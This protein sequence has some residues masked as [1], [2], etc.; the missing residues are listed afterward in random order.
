M[1]YDPCENG[2]CQNEDSSDY[3]SAKVVDLVI[4]GI[5]VFYVLL[6]IFCYIYKT[7]MGLRESRQR[8]TVQ[9]R[10]SPTSSS[11]SDVLLPPLLLTTRI[12]TW[13]SM[14]TMVI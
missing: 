2:Q 1:S 7:Q 9:R 5:F 14:D 6:A 10:I 12:P 4:L 11:S 3:P 13:E 8:S